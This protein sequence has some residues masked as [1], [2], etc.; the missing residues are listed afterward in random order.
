MKIIV[1]VKQ[2]VDPEE[3]P[4]SFGVDEVA[5]K[6][7][8]PPGVPSVISPFDK[9]AVEAALRVRD[10]TGGTV[11]AISLGDSL[12]RSVLRD[13][14]A[15]GSDE[16]VI[17]EDE[18]FE[19]GDAWS[20]AYALAMGIKKIGDYGLIF[21]GRQESDWDDGQVGTYMAS[22]LDIPCITVAKKIDVIDGK[23]KVERVTSDGHEVV[24]ASL[25]AV[26]TVSNELG[27]PRYPTVKQTMQARKIKPVVWNRDDI[28]VLEDQV[29]AAGRRVKLLKLFKPIRDTQ[30][31]MIQGV[32]PE[33]AGANLAVKLR[34]ANLL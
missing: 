6:I 18:A 1:C 32:S 11:T 8:L 9:Q 2:V 19:D 30:C 24:E 13:P 26:I 34:E 7:T 17:L 16:L 22:I 20:T 31:E 10:E 21:C 12:D 15:M 14:L 27:E 33:E 28:G 25:P 5:N 23:V 29:G 4:A 3:P